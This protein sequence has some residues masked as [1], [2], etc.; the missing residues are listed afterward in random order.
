MT[1][2][3]TQNEKRHLIQQT[4]P[5]NW[6]FVYSTPIPRKILHEEL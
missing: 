2:V 6:K 4:E 1:E 5:H 3:Q